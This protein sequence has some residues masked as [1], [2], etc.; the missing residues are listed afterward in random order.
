LGEA[1]D[2]LV[3]GLHRLPELAAALEAG[4]LPKG[5]PHGGQQWVLELDQNRESR[6]AG[7]KDA[8]KLPPLS[9]VLTPMELDPIAV[10]D[11]D[12]FVERI[13]GQ[14]NLDDQLKKDLA[15]FYS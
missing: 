9:E 2:R 10:A 5:L 4:A 3:D 14:R 7:A 13:T 8:K 12:Q 11:D 6:I 15:A 1:R